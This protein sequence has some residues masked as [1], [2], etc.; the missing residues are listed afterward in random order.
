[1]TQLNQQSLNIKEIRDIANSFDTVSIESCMQL[2]MENKA[3]PCFENTELEDVM[4]ILAK[5]NFV[6]SQVE[7]GMSLA[8]AMRELGKRMRFVQGTEHE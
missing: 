3:N 7:Q 5:A 8:V 2:A 6:R 4:N 1:M